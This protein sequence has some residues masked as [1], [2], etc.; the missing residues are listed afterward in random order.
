MS[1]GVV[2]HDI[3]IGQEIGNPAAPRRRIRRNSDHLSR[4]GTRICHRKR[5][6]Q[7]LGGRDQQPGIGIV[8]TVDQVV[9]AQLHISR[10]RHRADSLHCQ[11]GNDQVDRVRYPQDH[12]IAPPDPKGPQRGCMAMDLP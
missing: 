8:C 2:R 11:Q 9:F 4:T 10:H 6:I 12:D 3:A 7:Q 1:I 5:L